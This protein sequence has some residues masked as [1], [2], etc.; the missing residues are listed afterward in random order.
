MRVQLTTLITKELKQMEILGKE[1]LFQGN[2][3]LESTAN[4]IFY[5]TT[6]TAINI[7]PNNELQSNLEIILGG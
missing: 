3:D 7:T 4:I 5:D 1:N 2:V 6:A